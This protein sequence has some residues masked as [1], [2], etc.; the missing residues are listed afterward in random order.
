ML[1]RLDFWQRDEPGLSAAERLGRPPHQFRARLAEFIRLGV[2]QFA[3]TPS[4]GAA[5]SAHRV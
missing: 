3:F 2:K 1:G 5:T 4:A